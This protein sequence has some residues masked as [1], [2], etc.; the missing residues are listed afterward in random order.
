MKFKDYIY[1]KYPDNIY[2]DIFNKMPIKEQKFFKDTFK[3]QEIYIRDFGKK[4]HAEILF[5]QYDNIDTSKLNTLTKKMNIEKITIQN[6][7]TRLQ[8]VIN[9]K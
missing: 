3:N 2:T 4:V 8:I 6:N 9:K 7:P 5:S 1:E